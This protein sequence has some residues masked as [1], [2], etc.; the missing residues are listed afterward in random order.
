MT[1]SVATFKKT[2]SSSG[3]NPGED[4]PIISLIDEP[5]VNYYDT[6]FQNLGSNVNSLDPVTNSPAPDVAQDNFVFGKTFQKN[7]N[8]KPFSFN[9]NQNSLNTNP[10]YAPEEFT[11]NQDPI[12][13]DH[14]EQNDNAEDSISETVE[15]D[16]DVGGV[17]VSPA[18]V[19]N[20]VVNVVS[21]AAPVSDA[22]FNEIN[23]V[24][25][26]IP[27]KP[28]LL[29][30]FFEEIEQ[31]SKKTE[32]ASRSLSPQDVFRKRVKSKE[33]LQLTNLVKTVEYKPSDLRQTT[34][35]SSVL[36]Y[37][38]SFS[39]CDKLEQDGYC[40]EE[41]QSKYTEKMVESL[42]D[43]CQDIVAA[44]QAF[45][46]ED[47]DSLG[48]NSQSVISSEKDQDR[49]WSWTVSAYNKRQVCQS[50]L[51][52]IKPSYALNTKGIN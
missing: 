10:Y 51:S 8:S 29:P 2:D 14:E 4:F 41:N 40:A 42:L 43:N 20:N 28:T 26:N 6:V 18:Q 34:N 37:V 17:T 19:S 33:Q 46:P 30:T 9:S 24:K 38:S 31:I 47:I 16:D 21:P 39:K 3:P 27:V 22:G 32:K 35:K 44:F 1:P 52:F 50:S 25:H 36:N 45:V 15:N 49:P 7:F 13:I 48:D 5:I 11:Y 12:L 23:D